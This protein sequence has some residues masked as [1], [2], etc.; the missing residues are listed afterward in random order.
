VRARARRIGGAV[1]V[2]RGRRHR[3]RDEPANHGADLR[4]FF[5]TKFTGRGTGLAA[6][7]GIVRG[8]RGAIRVESELGRG[9]TFRLLL[10]ATFGVAPKPLAAPAKPA[11]RVNHTG[12]VLVEDDE[13][14]VRLVICRAIEKAGNTAVPAASGQKAPDIP[15]ER[16][17]EFAVVLPGLTMPGIDGQQV[18][19]AARAINGQMP[20]L[21]IGGL[22]ESEAT[23]KFAGQGLA[24][25]IQK[26]FEISVLVG[27]LSRAIQSRRG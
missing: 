21:L 18:F 4:A 16:H 19:E 1:C 26:P 25:F 6:V 13:D 2:P 23:A 5:S 14:R 11:A 8:H 12:R 24:G 15:G 22:S 20:V 7:L 3:L 27:Q 9:A 17:R 10:P